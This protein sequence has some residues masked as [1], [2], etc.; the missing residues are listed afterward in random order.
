MALGAFPS[1]W[2]AEL[3]VSFALHPGDIGSVWFE[4][5]MRFGGLI[6]F[7][8]G[9]LWVG[10]KAADRAYSMETTSFAA[11][12]AKPDGTFYKTVKYLGGGKSFGT[13]LVSIFK[14]Y[15]R[16]LENLS[17]IVYIVGLL[18]M[19][20]VFFGGGDDPTGAMILGIFIFP[21][22]FTQT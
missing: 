10:A 17:K 18:I 8:V 5:L 14:D 1:S 4:T 7:F 16:R 11:T 3:M 2:G 9:A 15:G 13:L 22:L 19:I 21:M 12:S 6:L 20:N